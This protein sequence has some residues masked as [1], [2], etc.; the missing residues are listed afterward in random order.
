MGLKEHNPKF[1][2]FLTEQAENDKHNRERARQAF[3]D[4][5]TC[6]NCF[7]GPWNCACI[8]GQV[9]CAWERLRTR[10]QADHQRRIK[11]FEQERKDTNGKNN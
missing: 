8:V 2:A 5:T 6:P 7:K 3:V 10:R 9:V 1:F 4:R 11:L